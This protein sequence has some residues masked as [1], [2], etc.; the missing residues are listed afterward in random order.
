MERLPAT[1]P[2][3]SALF[4]SSPR[5]AWAQLH[6]RR[7]RG[8]PVATRGVQRRRQPLGQSCSRVLWLQPSVARDMARGWGCPWRP[9]QQMGRE[10]L[11]GCPTHPS[12]PALAFSRLRLGPRYSLQQDRGGQ[13]RS[14]G[15]VAVAGEPVVAAKAAL[16]RSC[17]DRRAVAALGCPLLRHVSGGRLEEGPDPS[18][19]APSVPNSSP[20]SRKLPWPGHASWLPHGCWVGGS[21]EEASRRL[22]GLPLAATA[23]PRCGWLSWGRPS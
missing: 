11:L 4:P 15:R 10:D 16:V 20:P 19:P 18:K 9:F 22:T 2:G 1:S 13:Q 3:A 21:P 23:T 6:L 8:G 5:M 7:A 14:A 12:A 17:G